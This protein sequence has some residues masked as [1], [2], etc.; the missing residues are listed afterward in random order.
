[1]FINVT[2]IYE[3][4]TLVI[5][6]FRDNKTIMHNLQPNMLEYHSRIHVPLQMR[7]TRPNSYKL[8]EPH[9]AY[10]AI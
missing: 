7:I 5:I 4:L 3:F 6:G 9:E 8:Y 10:Q 2:L 1:M